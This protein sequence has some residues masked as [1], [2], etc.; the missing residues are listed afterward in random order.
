MEKGRLEAFSDGVMGVAITLM[1]IELKAPGVGAGLAAFKDLVVE[2]LD[3]VLSFVFVGI[4]WSNHHHMFKAVSRV[5]GAILWAN[6]FL[7]FW[8]TLFPFTTAW[9]SRDPTSSPATATY[10][11]VLLMAGVAYYILQSLLID[12]QGVD[13]VLAKAVGFDWKGKASPILY[14]AAIPLAFISPWIADGLYVVVALMWLVP[15]RRI[16]RALTGP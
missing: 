2:F 4:Y 12:E 7:L 3:Y 16:E 9:V 1:V 6:L 5:N 14:I 8:I 13:S 10:G 11:V 15:D